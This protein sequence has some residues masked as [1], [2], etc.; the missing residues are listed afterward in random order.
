MTGVEDHFRQNENCWRKAFLAEA[1]GRHLDIDYFGD[2]E[3]PVAVI[4]TVSDAGA[5][6]PASCLA[7]R[8]R[9]PPGNRY[10]FLTKWVRTSMQ[11]IPMQ[12]RATRGEP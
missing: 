1:R 10:C 9:K 4:T 2:A 6:F 12:A 7:I 3:K 11:A 5:S 8:A